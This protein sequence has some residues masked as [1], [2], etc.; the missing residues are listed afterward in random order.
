MT[1]TSE[2]PGIEVER[3]EVEH[4]EPVVETFLDALGN[5]VSCD[6]AERLERDDVV[7]A[8]TDVTYD[9][10]WAEASLRQTGLQAKLVPVRPSHHHRYW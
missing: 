4:W 8:I 1:F 2:T 7:H 3:Y 5:H 10:A 9:V 6:A